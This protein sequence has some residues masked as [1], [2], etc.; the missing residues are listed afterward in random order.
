MD[1]EYY[2]KQWLEVNDQI[3]LMMD[4]FLIITHIFT[5]QDINWWTGALWIACE[6]LWRFYQLF[7]LSFWRHPFTAE[8]EKLMSP[9]VLLS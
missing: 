2:W 3:F 7:G 8:D 6:L 4:L 1:R 5:S 9:F